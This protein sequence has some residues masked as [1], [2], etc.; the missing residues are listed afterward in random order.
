[1]SDNRARKGVRRLQPD[2]RENLIVAEAVRFF[3]EAGFGGQTRE[4]ARR[5]G[6]THALL[7]HYFESKDA[8]IDRVYDE[9]FA[10]RWKPQ[11]ETLLDDR[12]IP[13]RDRLVAFY[14]DYART[15]LSY[16]WVRIFLFSGLSGETINRRYLDFLREHVFA[17]VVREVR[18]DADRSPAARRRAPSEAEIEIVWGLHASIFY[19]G[20]RKWVYDLPVPD[21]VDPIIEAKVVAFLDGARHAFA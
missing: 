1:M 17:R 10:G 20:I 7:F 18:V 15:I 12:S 6:I 11:W 9:V 14:T 8:L 3:A 4:L 16:E 5:L 13:I 2:E 21:D 19:M